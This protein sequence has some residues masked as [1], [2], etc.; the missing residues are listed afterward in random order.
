MGRVRITAEQTTAPDGRVLT[1]A[2]GPRRLLAV[3]VGAGTALL[4]GSTA[5]LA[6]TWPQE[7]DEPEAVSAEELYAGDQRAEELRLGYF[8]NVTHAPALVGLQEDLFAEHLHGTAFHAETFTAGPAALEALT[9]GAVDAAFIGPNPAIHSYAQSGGESVVVVSG[10]AS[11]GVQLIVREGIDSPEDLAGRELATPQLGGTQDVAAR[12]WLHEQGLTDEV[13][14]TPTDN[15]QVLRLF[16][17]GRVDAAWVPEPWASRLVEQAGGQV[18]VDERELWPEGEFPTT[19]LA[20]NREYAEAHPQ[21]VKDLAAATDAAVAWLQTSEEAEVH[22]T[23]NAQLSEDVGLEL[24]EPVLTRALAHVTFTT[25]P[26]ASAFPQLVEDSVTAGTGHDVALDGLVVPA[27]VEPG[28]PEPTDDSEPSD[29]SAQ[30]D[31][32]GVPSAGQEDR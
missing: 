7:D 22:S 32:D 5:V 23:L 9:A 31:D 17:Q 20:V 4:V 18:L 26:V 30:T 13:D 19:V 12:V 11:G 1:R 29:D 24:P 2:P 21:T 14:I 15:P 28:S 8:P 10:A 16:E 6:T 27:P 25:D 3:V